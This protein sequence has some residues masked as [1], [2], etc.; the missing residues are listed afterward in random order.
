MLVE[1]AKPTS[2]ASWDYTKIE[3]ADAS[4]GPWTEIASQ[5]IADNTYYDESGGEDNYYRIRHYDS[6]TGIYSSYSDVA[7]GVGYTTY[8][9]STR[10]VA[11]YLQVPE[12]GGEGSTAPTIQDVQ[13]FIQDAEEELDRDIGHAWKER[14]VSEE[15]HDLNQLSY[16]YGT[17]WPIYLGFRKVR[18]LDSDEGDKIEIWDGE[19]WVDWVASSDYTEGR[20]EDYWMDYK[21]GILWI[22]SLSGTSYTKMSV[23]VTYRYGDTSVPNDIRK[24]CALLAAI[25]ILDTNDRTILVPEGS[26]PSIN[27]DRKIERW[28]A[29]IDKTIAS[30]AEIKFKA[31]GS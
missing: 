12:F 30:R 18:T 7:T 24:A 25:N 8:Y 28:Q 6:S 21:N 1:W 26:P 20:D 4:T 14:S 13:R 29:Q 11:R 17:G 19:N 5:A 22:K 23:K 27:W 9:C 31:F 10:D 15:M 3:R 2:E 16:I